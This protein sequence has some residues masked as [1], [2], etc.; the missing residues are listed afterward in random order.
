MWHCFIVESGVL[1]FYVLLC[2]EPE[3]PPGPKLNVGIQIKI[4]LKNN[5]EE[6]S[7]SRCK[8][9]ACIQIEVLDMTKLPPVT[10]CMSGR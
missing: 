5:Y 3:H 10:E 8:P 9:R 2:G 4:L 1:I 6:T 7:T